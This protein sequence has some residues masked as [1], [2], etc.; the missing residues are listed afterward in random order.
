MFVSGV[1][2]SNKMACSVQAVLRL[3]SLADVKYKGNS[4][5]DMRIRLGILLNPKTHM[6]WKRPY[7]EEECI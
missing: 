7:Y 3:H 1:L 4:L 6:A 5:D 2:K